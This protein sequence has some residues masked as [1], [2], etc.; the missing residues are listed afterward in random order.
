MVLF[1]LVDAVAGVLD[2]EGVRLPLAHLESLVELVQ[3]F[4]GRR[5]VFGVAVEKEDCVLDAL[6]PVFEVDEG[7]SL[8]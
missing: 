1:A 6:S 2:D 3:H 4:N 8:W 7:Q 5:R